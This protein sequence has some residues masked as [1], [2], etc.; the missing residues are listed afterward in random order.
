[1]WEPDEVARMCYERYATLPRRGKPEE[2][3]EWTQLAAVIQVTR[4]PDTHAVLKEV[5][6]LGTGTKCIGRS[7][8]NPKGDVLNDSHAE[9]IARRSCVRYLME[10]LCVVMRGG[11]SSVFCRADQAGKW[12]IRPDVSFLFFCSHTPCGDASI[13]PMTESQAQPCPPVPRANQESEQGNR[14]RSAES[15][16]GGVKKRIRVD[17]QQDV[18]DDPR[19]IEGVEADGA[20]VGTDGAGVGDA[21]EGVGDAGEGVGDDRAG[22]GDAGEGVGDDRAG[23]GL[24]SERVEVSSGEQVCDVHRTG[25]KCVPGAPSD[26]RGPGLDFHT[27]GALRVKPGRGE[28]TLSL[29][30]SDK[31]SRWCTLGFQGA[32]LS[33]FLQEGV[34]FSAVVV[35]KCPYSRHALHRAISRCASVT[36]LPAGFSPHTPEL[37]QSNVEFTHG[38]THTLQSHDASQQ[39]RVVPCGAA[40]SWCS[41]S[42]QPLDVTANGYKQGVTKKSLGTPQA[43]SLISKVELFHSFLKLLELVDDSELP[44]SLRGKD[45]S[46]YWDYKV[47]A[48]EYQQAWIALRTQVFTLWPQ[49][50]RHL[51]HF[52]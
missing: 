37:L 12:R 16:T 30:C 13:I 6:A 18:S 14:K 36:G 49:S 20:V 45:L 2:G 28:A 48:D 51:L 39:G 10:Q 9:V 34:Y 7:V 47:A 21:G 22:V 25:A 33:H 27:V 35:G 41:V 43:R 40:I 44:D 11:H 5:V 17:R 42:S 29:S 24:G 31:L 23:V 46:T 26:P 1:M 4:C 50:P 8:M 19:S 15:E 38:R 52:T 32:L 3:R